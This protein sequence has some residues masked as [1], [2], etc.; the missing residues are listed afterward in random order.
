MV[1]TQKKK[2]SNRRLLRHLDDF[3]QDIIISNT[4][5]DKQEKTTVNEATGSQVF[6]INNPGSS[7]TVIE[8]AMNVKTLGTCFTEKTRKWVILLTRSKTLFE[9]QF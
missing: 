5:S 9:T 6:T 4:A 7:L 2:Q 8:N 3:D 1:S